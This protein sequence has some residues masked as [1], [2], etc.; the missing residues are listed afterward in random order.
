VF[1]VSKGRRFYGP[2][3]TY[4]VFAGKDASRAFATGCFA[5]SHQTDD[6]RG[7]TEEQ[8]EELDNWY[9]FYMKK[10]TYPIMGK[11]EPSSL[12]NIPVPPKE[13]HVTSKYYS[14]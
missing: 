7:L 13:C 14:D 9:Q 8:L 1:D 12:D 3:A 4:H 5:P 10:K 11:V 2:D 6:L